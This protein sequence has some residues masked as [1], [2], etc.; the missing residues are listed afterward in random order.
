MKTPYFLAIVIRILLVA[1]IS[2]ILSSCAL[3]KRAVQVSYSDLVATPEKYA[4]MLVDVE[5][6]LSMSTELMLFENPNDSK[7]GNIWFSYAT[8]PASEKEMRG[9]DLLQSAY[10]N[11]PAISQVTYARVLRVRVEGRFL[12]AGKGRSGF[13]HLGAFSSEI[14]IERVLEVSS[15]HQR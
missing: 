4:G 14:V 12:Y 7:R 8:F 3:R 15:E 10:R 9:F 11:A 13:G 5:G 6:V 2:V 1:S